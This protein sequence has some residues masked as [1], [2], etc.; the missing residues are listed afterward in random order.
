MILPMSFIPYRT[1]LDLTT[2]RIS[3]FL[4]AGVVVSEIAAAL[5]SGRRANV[6]LFD[7]VR[8]FLIVLGGLL[9]L[10]WVFLFG[11]SIQRK[12]IAFLAGILGS[13]SGISYFLNKPI[14]PFSDN[15]YA[16]KSFVKLTQDEP[17]ALSYLNSGRGKGIAIWVASVTALIPALGAL[18]WRFGIVITAQSARPRTSNI[19]ETASA[20]I[21]CGLFCTIVAGVNYLLV[22]CRVL[23]RSG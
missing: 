16:P 18:C 23:W 12:S 13:F 3:F 7:L 10:P 22:A 4:A 21:M 15:A 6:A 9:L 5:G 11:Y 2:G 14:N 17:R 1:E 8:F 19:E 20:L